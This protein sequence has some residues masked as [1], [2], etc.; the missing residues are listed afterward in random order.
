V[1][2]RAPAGFRWVSCTQA[3]NREISMERHL[4]T[5]QKM[6]EPVGWVTTLCG[7]TGGGLALH[8]NL[9]QGKNECPKCWTYYEENIK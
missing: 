1:S 2:G 6:H 7:A 9:I 3:S 5:R 8:G 4:A